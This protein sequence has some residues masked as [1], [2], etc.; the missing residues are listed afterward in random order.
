[1]GCL[2]H[3][4]ISHSACHRINSE[5]MSSSS[6]VS[7]VLPSPPS[8]TAPHVVTLPF[9]S[10]LSSSLSS[11]SDPSSTVTATLSILSINLLAPIYV[12]PID[13]RTGCIQPF[14]AFEWCQDSDLDW[15][16][17]RPA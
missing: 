17:R 14:A 13:S 11:T 12:R 7:S 1:M 6:L 9:G 4:N 15:E 8:I 2:R 5:L 10:A 3:P 16:Y